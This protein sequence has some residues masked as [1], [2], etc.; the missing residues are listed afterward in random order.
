MRLILFGIQYLKNR[1]TRKVNLSCAPRAS[2]LHQLLDPEGRL[3]TR[4]ALPWLILAAV[5]VAAALAWF[6]LTRGSG[7]PGRAMTSDSQALPPFHEIEIGGAANVTLV[8]GDAES[9]DVEA[10]ARGVAVDA[11]VAN[12]RL[13]I[14]SRDRRR[15][16]NGLLGR[17][18]AQPV[19]MTVHFRVLDVLTLT[20]TVK[21]AAHRVTAT[22]LRIAASGG[23]ALSID[24][25]HASS[26]RVSGSGALRAD[27]GG[28]VE[29]EDV[30][31]SGAGMYRAERLHAVNATVA[32]SGVGN[33]ALHAEKTLRAS[34]SGA[35]VIEYVGDPEVTEHV[36]GI[37]R[38]RRRESS[39][40]PGVRVAQWGVAVGV[41][42][43]SLNSSGAPLAGSRS[44]WTPA[45]IRMPVT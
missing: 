42:P 19:N 44:A 25:L 11:N 43:Q 17:G 8:Q 41:E 13:V 37:G 28:R 45:R 34:I 33:V 32:V 27:L 29:D 21:L 38:V 39:L 24:D 20:G 10:P 6:T 30:S 40:A 22:T 5:A 36:S 3:M 14:T 12:G 4:S 35:G 15:W 26:L 23:S 16:W 9:I 31:I 2:N 1:E 18:N 7:A